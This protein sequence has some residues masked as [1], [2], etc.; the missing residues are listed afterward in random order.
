MDDT[1][2]MDSLNDEMASIKGIQEKKMEVIRD[3]Q[4]E[5]AM[6]DDIK[7]QITALST[8]PISSCEPP[9]E[10]PAQSLSQL[11]Q[12]PTEAMTRP[13]REQDRVQNSVQSSKISFCNSCDEIAEHAPRLYIRGITSEECMALFNNHGLNINSAETNCVA[14]QNLVDCLIGQHGTK[15]QI[16]NLC[17]IRDWLR[18]LMD[19]LWN[20]KSA[21]VCDSC[22]Q[23]E[24][25][26]L[27]WVE[28]RAIWQ[29]IRDIWQELNRISTEI[30]EFIEC[31]RQELLNQI[32]LIWEEI[33]IIIRRIEDIEDALR[34]LLTGSSVLLQEGRD[35][36]LVYLNGFLPM[37][38]PEQNHEGIQLRAVTNP[39]S[40]QIRLR[41]NS[42]SGNINALRHG[43]P[44]NMV[45][46]GSQ[47]GA[48]NNP[49]AWMFS[50]GFLGDYAHLN[51]E[52]LTNS[53]RN[54]GVWDINPR[55]ARATWDYGNWHVALGRLPSEGNYRIIMAP[56][57][58]I[59][60][61]F[62]QGSRVFGDYPTV[63]DAPRIRVSRDFMW[64]NV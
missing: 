51:T 7:S 12:P 15:L 63:T 60:G 31:V 6:L 46:V 39:F 25:V 17:D 53:E 22:G 13:E 57:G 11:R 41:A 62:G 59:N 8:V 45:R 28:V 23:W 50:I 10:P 16:T 54:L 43:N 47:I 1:K 52:S 24:Q 58:P 3:I 32:N 38:A 40:T 5:I 20:V 29:Q 27:L 4:T 61:L 48:A 26:R 49:D 37:Q 35:Y 14:L 36:H 19:N 44:Q 55:S 33:R 56:T 34:S 64:L 9:N 21:L 18:E 2:K 42:A 30:L